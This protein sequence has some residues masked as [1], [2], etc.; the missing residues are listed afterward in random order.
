[1]ASRSRDLAYL[2]SNKIIH[3][4]LV[5]GGTLCV[6]DDQGGGMSDNVPLALENVLIIK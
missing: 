1:M 4:P 3:F 5:D 2:M 6:V